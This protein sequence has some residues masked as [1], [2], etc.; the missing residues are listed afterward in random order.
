M[1]TLFI[2][3]TL[4]SLNILGSIELRAQDAAPGIV[5]DLN[6]NVGIGGDVDIQGSLTQD[7]GSIFSNASEVAWG[8]V[9]GYVQRLCRYNVE[10]ETGGVPD[11]C[12]N[13]GFKFD[14][15]RVDKLV[16]VNINC[17]VTQRQDAA[18][19]PRWQLNF[20]GSLGGGTIVCYVQCMNLST[21]TPLKISLIPMDDIGP[22][23]KTGSDE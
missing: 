8:S 4:L 12:L 10:I 23:C 13:S 6:G 17:S 20:T 15:D 3:I 19:Q 14:Q 5:V 9:A 18:G 1:R 11:L 22:A 21:L 16:P 7:H 2:A